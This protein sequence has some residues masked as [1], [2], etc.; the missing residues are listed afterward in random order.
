MS[1]TNATHAI[2]RTSP[3]GGPFIGTCRL[4]GQTGLRAG[5]ALVICPNPGGVTS[6]E[7][8]IDVI[9]GP[10][11]FD[12]MSGP[13]YRTPY[14]VLPK[15]AIQ[16]M[17]LQWQHRLLALLEEANA[18]GLETP[19]YTVYRDDPLFTWVR[20]YDE[21]DL[22]VVVEPLQSDPWADYRRG[23]VKALSPNF[24]PT[25]AAGGPDG[26]EKRPVMIDYENW[27]GERRVRSVMPLSIF[28]GRTPWHR[29]P[30]WLMQAIDSEDGVEKSFAIADIHG[31]DVREPKGA[32]PKPSDFVAQL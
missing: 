6:D 3:K 2:E 27:R 17:P 26:A 10:R 28:F 22:D 24:D 5:D 4:C 8:L 20:K 12:S 9:D 16:A 7:A 13:L 14:L 21:S 1:K 18:T 15:L 32:H 25:Q 23:D 29:K 30:Q 19:T 31:W 11:P